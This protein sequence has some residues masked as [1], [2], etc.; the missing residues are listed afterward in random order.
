VGWTA[1]NRSP[2]VKRVIKVR[3]RLFHPSRPVLIEGPKQFLLN[4]YHLSSGLYKGV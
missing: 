3:I 4:D 1:L 2:R